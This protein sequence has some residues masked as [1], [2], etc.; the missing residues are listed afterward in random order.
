MRDLRCTID[1]LTEKLC[2]TE[3]ALKK[4]H[5]TKYSLQ[6]QI[7]NIKEYFYT[8]SGM[9]QADNHTPTS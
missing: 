6:D 8:L 1:K 5:E 2:L 7:G 4:L 9:Y 3:F